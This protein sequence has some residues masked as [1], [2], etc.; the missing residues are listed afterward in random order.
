MKRDFSRDGDLVRSDCLSR[1]EV[2]EG[3]VVL[4]TTLLP[5]GGSVRN[6]CNSLVEYRL[7]DVVLNR[8]TARYPTST[9]SPRQFLSNPKLGRV[10]SAALCSSI[11]IHDGCH[12]LVE[13][14]KLDKFVYFTMR[15]R[16]MLQQPPAIE[17][18]REVDALDEARIEG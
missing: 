13:L 12:V 16:K 8:S 14:S 3:I 10:K 1:R 17:H 11:A 6:G 5:R 15:G 4:F 7:R 2:C 9:G 18:D